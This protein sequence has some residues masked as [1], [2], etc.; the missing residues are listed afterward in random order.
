MTIGVAIPCY[1][2]HHHFL[3]QM[4]DS[5]AAQTRRPD[6]VVVS[7]SS[8]D[9]DGTRELMVRDIPVTIVYAARRI[10]QAENRN[11]AAGLLGTDIITFIDADDLMHPRRL[12]YIVRAFEETGC[13]GVVHNYEWV[14]HGE[15]V[16]YESEDQFACDEH[17]V[18]KHPVGVGGMTHGDLP[19]HHAHVSVTRGVFSRF[20]YP[21]EEQYYRM[22]DSVYVATLLQNG[23]AIRYLRNKLSHYRHY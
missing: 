4:F 1:K 18:T 5:I 23:V 16:P 12:E 21:T 10:V 14:A 9:Y 7:C 15:H 13:D 19:L 17:L 8:W 3:N 2:P 11:I 22:E 6:R 20:R